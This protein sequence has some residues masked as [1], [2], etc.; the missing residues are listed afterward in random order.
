MSL[1]LSL[2]LHVSSN[3]I[4]EQWNGVHVVNGIRCEALRKRVNRSANQQE[5]QEGTPSSCRLSLVT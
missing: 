3:L 5:N 1:A 4:D 2:W